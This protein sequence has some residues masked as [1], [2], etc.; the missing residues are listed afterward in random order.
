M[1]NWQGDKDFFA[2][3]SLYQKMGPGDVHRQ[4]LARLYT[5][6]IEFQDPLHQVSGIDNLTTYFAELYENVLELSFNF[7]HGFRKGDEGCVHWTMTYRHKNLYGGRRDIIVHGV[8]LL[9]WREDKVCR[10]RDFFD[11][12]ELLYEHIPLFGWGIRK[13]KERL[14]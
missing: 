4:L 12:G 10:Q 14:T 1:D 2:M 5:D 8:S 13:L 6:D 7:H 11:A 3:I 9:T